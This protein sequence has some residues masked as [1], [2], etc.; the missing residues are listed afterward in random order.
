MDSSSESREDVLHVPNLF[1]YFCSRTAADMQSRGGSV[2]EGP[3]TSFASLIVTVLAAFAFYVFGRPQLAKATFVLF[4]VLLLWTLW[5]VIIR[6]SEQI[7]QKADKIRAGVFPPAAAPFVLARLKWWNH[8]IVPLKWGR[9]SRLFDRRGKLER[10][11]DELEKEA[12]RQGNAQYV[13]P[14]EDESVAL[15]ENIRIFSD[16]SEY[17]AA[18]DKLPDRISQIRAMIILYRALLFKIHEMADKL[19]RIEKQNVV[20]QS[21]SPED[22]SQVVGEAIQLLEERRLLVINVDTVEPDDFIDLVSVRTA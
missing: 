13:P 6:S 14:T 17:E 22:L 2:E 12:A 9:H 21:I 19:D 7:S 15:A 3:A 20:F 8:L 4:G 10:K 1:D 11:I 5:G 16:R 18:V